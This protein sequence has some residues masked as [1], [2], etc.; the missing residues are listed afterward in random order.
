[1]QDREPV[2]VAV[3]DIET[4]PGEGL[5]WR[6]TV[7]LRVQNPNDTLVE[8]DGVYLKMDVQDKTFA[9]GVSDERGSI[10]RYG[11]TV[12]SVPMTVSILRVALNVLSLLGS[13][14]MDK[15]SYSY[16]YRLEGKLDG[17]TFGSTKF[18]TEGEFALPAAIAPGT[19]S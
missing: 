11:E 1:L 16:N 18:H 5:E 17:P 2:Q 8:Y 15:I 3:A 13:D 7:K 6:M 12:V 4:L 14:R 19:S 10:P 9:T